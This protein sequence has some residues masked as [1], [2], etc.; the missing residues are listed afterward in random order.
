MTLGTSGAQPATQPRRSRWASAAMVIGGFVAVLY[1]IE[2]VDVASGL[3]LDRHG[4][5]PRSVDGLQGVAFAPLLHHGW[6]HLF[7]NT[8]PLLVLGFVLMLSGI[9]RGLAVTAVVWIVGGLGTWLTGETASLHVGASIIVFGWLSYLIVRGIFA[10]DLGQ[11]LVGVLVLLVYGSALWGVLPTQEDV[12][13]QGH[14]FGALAGVLAAWMFA[15]AARRQRAAR[16]LPP[17]P[18]LHR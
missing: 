6:D 10:R 13:W 14:L 8:V 12:S 1:V 3:A 4:I 2:A 16:T 9:A 15:G 17:S 11:L 18:T 5:G 7:A